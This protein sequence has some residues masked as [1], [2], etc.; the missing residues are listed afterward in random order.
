V[1]HLPKQ[2]VCGLVGSAIPLF[3]RRG[4]EQLGHKGVILSIHGSGSNNL[5]G[6]TH[7]RTL[8]DLTESDVTKSDVSESDVN[9]S[10]VPPILL[11]AE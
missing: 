10:G 6:Y 11:G 2:R 7:W 4:R 5:F 1:A 8:L 3:G 9:E